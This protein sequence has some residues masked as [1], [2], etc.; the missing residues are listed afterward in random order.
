MSNKNLSLKER[1]FV[2]IEKFKFELRLMKVNDNDFKCFLKAFKISIW[3]SIMFLILNII[4]VSI[5]YYI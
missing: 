3:L 5:G 1:I 2:F 4:V